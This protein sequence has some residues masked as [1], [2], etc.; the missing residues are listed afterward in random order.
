M[1]QSLA[2]LVVHLVFSTKNRE[3]LLPAEFRER[4]KRHIESQER[5]HR[6]RTFEEEF[7]ELLRRHEVEWDERH[8]WD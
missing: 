8:V 3:P 4:V 7:R 5:H 2:R 6:R 1:P